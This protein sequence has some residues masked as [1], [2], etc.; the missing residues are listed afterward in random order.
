MEAHFH[1]IQYLID[2]MGYKTYVEIGVRK[3]GTKLSIDHINCT[4][5]I[6]V[7]ILNRGQKYVMTSDEFFNTIEP[8]Q[9]YDIIFIDGDHEKTQLN[10]DI[11]NALKHLNENGSIVVHDINPSEERLLVPRFCNNSWEAFAKLRSEREDLAMYAFDIEAVGVG[12]I[13]KG[14]QILYTNPIEYT[15]EYLN[16]HRKELLNVIDLDKFKTIV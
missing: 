5:K 4:E 10:C 15:W 13:R 9:K 16:T 7:D 11:I 6:G 14:H 2:K 1:L 8:T 3:N 12:V